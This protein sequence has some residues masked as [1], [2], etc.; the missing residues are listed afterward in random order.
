MICI[1]ISTRAITYENVLHM[2]IFHIFNMK[3]LF[4]FISADVSHGLFLLFSHL[5][6]EL[7]IFYVNFLHHKLIIIIIINT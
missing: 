5:I 7:F 3:N 6:D 2:K 1:C 4:K